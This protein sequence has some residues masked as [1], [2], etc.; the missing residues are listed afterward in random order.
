[1]H[2]P[3]HRQ[4]L[5]IL[6]FKVKVMHAPTVNISQTVTYLGQSLIDLDMSPFAT[7]LGQSL[8]LATNRKSH[9]GFRLAD[10]NFT[11]AYSKSQLGNWNVVSPNIFAFLFDSKIILS[12]K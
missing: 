12:E 5:P 1:M 9:L 3:F 6:K 2:T 10:L 4:I 11:L 7:Y 8:M